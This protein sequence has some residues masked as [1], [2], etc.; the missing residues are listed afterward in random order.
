MLAFDLYC[1][2]MRNAIA[3][4]DTQ[5]M[6]VTRARKCRFAQS[7]LVRTAQSGGLTVRVSPSRSMLAIEALGIM[8]RSPS[9]HTVGVRWYGEIG[10]ESARIGI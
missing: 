7:S 10:G 6:P 8:A 1:F 3:R 9:A 5:Q 2:G 4:L